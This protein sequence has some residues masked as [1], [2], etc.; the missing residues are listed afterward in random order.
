MLVNGCMIDYVRVEFFKKG[1]HSYF[2]INVG[3]IG[4]TLYVGMLIIQ[5]Q[6]D[7]M[8]RGFAL[9]TEDEDGGL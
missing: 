3:Q 1:S 5:F 9:V 6:F 8:Q 7:V 2:I 4:N